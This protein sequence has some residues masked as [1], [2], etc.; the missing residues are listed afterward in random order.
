VNETARALAGGGYS[1]II[2]GLCFVV[3]VLAGVVAWLTKGLLKAKD[4]HAAIRKEHSDQ[5]T[6]LQSAHAT[7]ILAVNATHATQ[8]ATVNESRIEEAQVFV[9]TALTLRKSI[10]IFEKL[11]GGG[12]RL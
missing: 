10:E 3:A 7:Q 4:Q 2:Y 5:I 9:E 12:R 1:G 6:G 11:S 8:L